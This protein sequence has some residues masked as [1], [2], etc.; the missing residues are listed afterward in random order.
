MPPLRQAPNRYR[1]CF[2][3]SANMKHMGRNKLLLYAVGLLF[4]YVSATAQN[5]FQ[6]TYGEL[7]SWGLNIQQTTDGGFII[8]GKIDSISAG[9]SDVYLIKLDYKGDTVWTKIYGGIGDER[10][11]YIIQTSDGG[12]VF[13]GYTFS[14]GAGDA[15]FFVVKTDSLGNIQWSKTYG[16]AG[17]D[18]ANKIQKTSDGNYVV[19]GGTNSF[20]L[21]NSCGVLLK[22][23][24]LGNIIWYK[25]YGELGYVYGSTGQQT[26]DDGFI[27][28]GGVTNVAT[29]DQN[30]CLI[31]TDSL[32]DLIWTKSYGDSNQ[33]A[34]SAGQQTSDGGYIFGRATSSFGTNGDIYLVKTDS[35][36]NYLW[37]KTYGGIS[38]EYA[39]AIHQTS[40]MGYAIF[41]QTW[42]FGVSFA[43]IDMILIKTDSLGTVQWSKIYGDTATEGPSIFTI[44]NDGY[45]LG[46]VTFSFGNN[47]GE[48]YLVKTDIGGSSGCHETNVTPTVTSP[49]TQ[50]VIYPITVNSYTP[51]V[52]SP[53]FVVNSGC[54]IN[55]LCT[56]V[57]VTEILVHDSFLI[58]PNPSNG[59]FIISL[60][61]KITKG[62]VTISNLLGENVFTTNIYN[63]SE[64]EINLRN[65]SPGIYLIKVQNG[66]EY[67][68]KKLIVEHD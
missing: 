62:N 63:E 48:F 8:L 14:F 10:G 32:G 30:A 47:G 3:G 60:N 38:S 19:F 51:G 49:A 56:N 16:G 21:G 68:C 43:D 11:N 40:D 18:Y 27:L 46:G 26:L 35:L 33:D 29:N 53:T 36:G 25:T 61:G 2:G 24:S 65:V 5:T 57:G 4:Y 6:K 42:S 31:K 58:S 15:D 39:I 12:F 1:I 59:N 37:S 9:S 34:S 44:T 23:D 52:L 17:I 55:T 28:I 22:I 66:N 45:I 13:T 20:G 7:K 54:M 50:T 64:K 67:Y 41:G